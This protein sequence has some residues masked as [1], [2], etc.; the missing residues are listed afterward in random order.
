MSVNT[1]QL[2]DRARDVDPDLRYMALEDFQKHLRN[3]LAPQRSVTFFVPLLFQLLR[4]SATDVQNQAVR[5][6]PPLVRRLEDADVLLVATQLYDAVGRAANASHFSISVPTLALRG[7]F[8]EAR[9]RF[10]PSLARATYAALLPLLLAENVSIDNLEIFIDMVR[11]V[12]HVLSLDELAHAVSAML[13][14]AYSETGILSKRAIFAADA[15]LAYLP[16]AAHD[17]SQTQ[18]QFYDAVVSQLSELSKAPKTDPNVSFTLARC[19]LAPASKTRLLSPAAV[20]AIF[21]KITLCLLLDDL[22][23]DLDDLDIDVL[24]ERNVLR[25]NALVTLSALIPC[26]AGPD[27]AAHYADPVGHIV[28]LFI[29]Y[30]PLRFLA[31]DSEEDD[32]EFEFSDDEVEQFEAPDDNDGLAAKLRLAAVLVLKSIFVAQQGTLRAL[33]DLPL[34]PQMAAAISDASEVVS[35]EAIVASVTL[36]RV[37][38]DQSLRPRSRANSDVSMATESGDFTLLS[39]FSRKYAAV[40][41]R[42]VFDTLLSHKNFTRLGSSTILIETLVRYLASYLSEEFLLQLHAAFGSMRVSLKSHSEI[43]K[44]YNCILEQ[45]E[46]EEIPR[47]LLAVFI[48]NLTSFFADASIYYSVITD[49]LNG[50]KILF[51]KI[52]HDAEFSHTMNIALFPAIADKLKTKSF[53]SDMRQHFLYCLT[54]LVINI[55]LTDENTSKTV[56]I[57]KECLNIEMTVNFTIECMVK[58]FQSKPAVLTL[59]ELCIMTIERL[60]SFLSSSESSLYPSSLTL[61]ECIFE[62]QV[63]VGAPD[64]LHKLFSVLETFLAECTDPSL[65]GKCFYVLNC[66][67]DFIGADSNTIR[68][69]FVIINEKTEATEDVDTKALELM[70][71]KMAEHRC[72]GKS[73]LFNLGV[74]SL[75]LK[76]FVSAKIMALISIECDLQ[77]ET[78]AIEKEL[79]EFIAQGDVGQVSKE[80]IVFNIHYLGCISAH[81]MQHQFG[82]DD[83]LAILNSNLDDHCRYAAARAVGLCS[84]RDPATYLPVILKLY[85]S[86]DDGEHKS[87]MMLMAI[88]QFMKDEA[89]REDVTSLRTLWSEISGAI[90]RKSGLLSHKDVTE[91]KLAGEILSEIIAADKE[92]D[93]QDVVLEVLETLAQPDFNEFLLY[94]IVVIVKVMVGSPSADFDVRIVE[95]IMQHLARPSLELK[96]AIISTL[97]TGIYNMSRVFAGILDDVILPRIFDELSAKEEFKKVIPMGPY[98]YVVDEGLEVRKLS[99]ELISAIVNV[100]A[101]KIDAHVAIDEVRIF[102]VLLAKGLVDSENDIINLAIANLL[103]ILSKDEGVLAKIGNQQELI[104]S[105][106]KISNRKM[107]SKASTQEIES[108]EDTLRSVIKFSKSINSILTQSNALSNEWTTF[109]LELK[110]KHHLLFSAMG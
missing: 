50:C 25:E 48:Q 65:I 90:S 15:C 18:T 77:H 93:Y 79:Q 104:G 110:N 45:F 49:I 103:Q 70:V 101:D 12:G 24:V 63:D 72:I 46:L 73:E 106:A 17:D 30:D 62:A 20:A 76:N 74:D 102:E 61:L 95:E 108:F 97:L 9:A 44:V 19:L 105:L 81:E 91:L 53:S 39:K 52:S 67:F 36:V 43:V 66:L 33:L 83:F 78:R 8:T 56:E 58:V 87:T 85:N 55:E 88:K 38:A 11:A 107:R 32:S 1:R 92:K 10:S 21:G 59:P 27:F 29:A 26:I 47:D 7:I 57:F 31:S 80:K 37:C 100:N 99:Y 34:V 54:N 109:F 13:R 14:A 84:I 82:F 40:F 5:T 68:S 3:P 60:A 28:A 64:L 69:L 4:D 86:C 71:Q 41:E 89:A 98:K 42:Q 23:V 94:T 16:L 51:E 75:A 6:F 22:H 35:S 2:E 96:L